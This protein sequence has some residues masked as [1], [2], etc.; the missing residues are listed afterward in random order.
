MLK[1]FYNRKVNIDDRLVPAVTAEDAGKALVV[2]EDGKITTGEAGGGKYIHVLAVLLNVASS[3]DWNVY[4]TIITDNA[5]E[6]T[7]RDNLIADMISVYGKSN[8]RPGHV[9]PASL[10]F[11]YNNVWYAVDYI[12]IDNNGKLNTH[13]ITFDIANTSIVEGEYTTNTPY[14][15]QDIVIAL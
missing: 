4:F 2:G 9:I 15:R 10:N 11:V 5:N 1:P 6:Y 12:Y 8:I 13:V 7:N 3:L 14:I